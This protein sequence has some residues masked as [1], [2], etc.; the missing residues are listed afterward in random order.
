MVFYEN[1]LAINHIHIC[2]K[3]GE[4][5]RVFGTISPNKSILMYP[6]SGII[7]DGKKK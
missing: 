4:M 6:I 5:T 2:G 1:A 7:L 3:R